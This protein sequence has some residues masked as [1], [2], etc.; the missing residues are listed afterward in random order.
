MGKGI[1]VHRGACDDDKETL[2]PPTAMRAVQRISSSSTSGSINMVEEDQVQKVVP[3]KLRLEVEAR[4][5]VNDASTHLAS[6]DERPLSEQVRD[7]VVAFLDAIK[8][9]DR[10]RAKSV[11][12]HA[13]S[14]GFEG[15]IKSALRALYAKKGKSEGKTLQQE[16][17]A[18]RKKK[19]EDPTA[20]ARELAER[21]LAP[22]LATS[23]SDELSY[24]STAAEYM[25]CRSQAASAVGWL[26]GAPGLIAAGPPQ[27]PE[28]I[29]TTPPKAKQDQPKNTSA[30]IAGM[31]EILRKEAELDMEK[32]R[33]EL[34]GAEARE[35]AQEVAQSEEYD[36]LDLLT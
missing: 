10:E 27:A 16:A 32:A 35:R 3:E 26:P 2:D 22:A 24:A 9:G 13:R 14:V 29:A 30:I 15:E 5:K 20:K 11:I 18:R 8:A 31:K 21:Q 23:Q 17:D 4:A 1:V 25:A 34:L 33:A 36:D 6:E 19:Q 7:Q 12:V 28:P